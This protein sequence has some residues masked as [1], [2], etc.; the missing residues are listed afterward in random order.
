MEDEMAQ[1]GQSMREH[2]TEIL[3]E[4]Y[5]VEILEYH[6]KNLL[7]GDNKTRSEWRQERLLASI[8]ILDNYSLDGSC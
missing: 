1:E 4:I 6:D 2:L 5:A 8:S 7:S 3:R